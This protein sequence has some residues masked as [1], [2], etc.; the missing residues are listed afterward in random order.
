MAQKPDAP[1]RVGGYQTAGQSNT[2]PGA[3]DFLPSAHRRR[4]SRVSGQTAG[5]TPYIAGLD[6]DCAFREPLKLR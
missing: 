1:K 6:S 2:M 4:N 5:F 3:S